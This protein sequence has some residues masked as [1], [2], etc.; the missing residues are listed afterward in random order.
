MFCKCVDSCCVLIGWGLPVEVLREHKRDPSALPVREAPSPP[1]G[2][3]YCRR[4]V[5]GPDTVGLGQRGALTLLLAQGR[6]SLGWLLSVSSSLLN[7][8]RASFPPLPHVCFVMSSS[9]FQACFS[10]CP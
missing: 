6:S 4:S 5:L 2:G 8:S 7:K 1:P 10:R 3:L 9:T